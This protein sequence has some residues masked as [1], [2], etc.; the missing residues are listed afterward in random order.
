MDAGVE[1]SS[2]CRVVWMLVYSKWCRICG[3]RCTIYLCIQ[4]CGKFTSL[5]SCKKIIAYDFDVQN[6]IVMN[7]IDTVIHI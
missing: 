6:R 3:A 2:S 7:F 1:W 5:N 4:S